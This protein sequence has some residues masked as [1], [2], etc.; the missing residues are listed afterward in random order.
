M[1]KGLFIGALCVMGMLFAG[2]GKDYPNGEV[3][4]YNWGEYINEDVIEMF[5]EEYGIEVVYDTFTENEDMYP[6]VSIGEVN[7]DVVCPSDYMIN[8][9]IE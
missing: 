2:C 1:K 9:M 4:V 8:R 5:E 6:I 7:Y 3:V